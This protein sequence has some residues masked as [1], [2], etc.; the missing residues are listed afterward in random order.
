[1]KRAEKEAHNARVAAQSSTLDELLQRAY[2]VGVSLRALALRVGEVANGTD[3][4]NSGR[5]ASSGREPEC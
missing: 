5:V 2:A 3:A 1:M 4:R